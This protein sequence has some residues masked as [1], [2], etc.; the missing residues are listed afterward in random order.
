MDR[1]K[2]VVQ[3][4]SEDL[5]V[6]EEVAKIREAERK[7]EGPIKAFTVDEDLKLRQAVKTA[8]PGLF[9]VSTCPPP[10]V[11]IIAHHGK[12]KDIFE[13]QR[14][15]VVGQGPRREYLVLRRSGNLKVVDLETLL[16]HADIGEYFRFS[17]QDEVYHPQFM[18]N[19]DELRPLYKR[20]YESWGF[21]LVF[22]E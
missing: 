14:W 22:E 11:L 17:G 9:A 6:Y 2:A 15:R 16:K 12:D 3:E 20:M 7:G 19:T 18:P 1:L 13:A 10:S 4:G 21:V 5:K 8:I